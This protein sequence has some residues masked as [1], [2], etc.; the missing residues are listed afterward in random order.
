MM[1]V[2]APASIAGKQCYRIIY[3]GGYNV[4]AEDVL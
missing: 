1:Q 2:S 4:V 3:P